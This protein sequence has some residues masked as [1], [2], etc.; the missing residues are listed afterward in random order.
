MAADRYLFISSGS[1]YREPVAAGSD[2]SAPVIELGGRVP[3][4]IVSAEDYGGLKVL[5]ERVASERFPGAALVLR[6]GLVVGPGDP[7]ERFVYW[8]RRVARGG[9]VLVAEPDQPVQFIDARDL[10]AWA[11]ALLE[12]GTVGVFNTVCPPL[13]M[14]ELLR[15]CADVSGSGASLDWVG[16]RFLHDHGVEPWTD[17]PLWLPSELAGFLAVDTTAAAAAGLRTRPVRDTVADV[18]RWDAT[19]DAAERRDALSPERERQLLASFGAR[20]RG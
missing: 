11:V 17:L 12:A 1:V 20:A 9:T 16:D 4:T 3:D 2:E 10:G 19:R 13:A 7:T 6:C 14:A 5:C 18:L 15:A 8:P